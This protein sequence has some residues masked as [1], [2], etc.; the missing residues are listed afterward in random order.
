MVQGTRKLHEKLPFTDQ[1]YRT[2]TR[3]FIGETPYFLMYEI[4][5]VTP[6]KVEIQSL[7]IVEAKIEDIGQ[8]KTR[9]DQLEL[10]DEKGLVGICFRQ[11]YQQSMARVYNERVQPRY[12][13]VGQLF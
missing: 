9:L 13:E 3:T 1:G 5:V 4:K 6:A 11:L 10:I 7:L 2:T 8:V 12:F